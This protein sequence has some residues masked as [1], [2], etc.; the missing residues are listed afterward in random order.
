MAKTIGMYSSEVNM[1]RIVKMKA[2]FGINTRPAPNVCLLGESPL[3][4]YI[5]EFISNLKT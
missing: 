1:P 5:L 4:K 2:K 3:G